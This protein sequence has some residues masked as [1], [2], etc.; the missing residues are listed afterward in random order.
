MRTRNLVKNFYR[1]S[2]LFFFGSINNV[3]ELQIIFR[4]FRHLNGN[5][6][7]C[8]NEKRELKIF[9]L[10]LLF[11]IN[12]L[13]YRA[14]TRIR[15]ERVLQVPKNLRLFPASEYI[16]HIGHSTLRPSDYSV[17]LQFRL[18]PDNS[19]N[20]KVQMVKSKCEKSF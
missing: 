10:H 4:C 2:F 5:C 12:E 19:R 15:S 6:F 13:S 14:R 20:A 11:H 1:R 16:G 9:L 8:R 17:E 3:R 18:N 7:A